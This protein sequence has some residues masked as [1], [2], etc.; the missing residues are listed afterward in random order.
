MFSHSQEY[1]ESVLKHLEQAIYNH[2]QWHKD[3]TRTFICRLPY[4]HRDVAE[5]AHRQC[6]FGQW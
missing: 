6:R 3:L 2:E 5:D 1:L 4:D